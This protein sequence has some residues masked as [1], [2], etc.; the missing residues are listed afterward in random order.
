MKSLA[1]KLLAV[2]FAFALFTG[3]A[4]VTDPGLDTTPEQN[5]SEVTQD[6]PDR[7]G[8]DSDSDM[9]TIYDKPEL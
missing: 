4:S 6:T 9:S 8:F 1:K 2:T 7:D 5:N 3:C